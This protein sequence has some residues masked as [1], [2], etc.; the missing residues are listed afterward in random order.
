MRIRTKQRAIHCLSITRGTGGECPLICK[1]VQIFLTTILYD[2]SYQIGGGVLGDV[3]DAEERGKAI[4]IYSLAP[5]LGP[6][7]G[8][9]CGAWYVL[10]IVLL[11]RISDQCSGS[12]SDQHGA[13][14]QVIFS[15][16]VGSAT[17]DSFKNA[18]FWST[19]IT[20]VAIQIA[21]LFLLQE[22]WYFFS[23]FSLWMR[24]ELDLNHSVRAP[25]A[26][27]QSC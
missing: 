1:F 2:P 19:S 17:N 13:G 8:P 20:D 14:W 6:V 26:R 18:Q 24:T 5:L 12:R 15:L 25:L 7:I 27:T 22:S 9:V 11:T 23:I 16:P 10:L 3:W 21:G 4:A